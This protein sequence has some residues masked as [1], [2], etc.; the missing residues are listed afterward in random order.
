[1]HATVKEQAQGG[2]DIETETEIAFKRFVFRR[3]WFM[4][5][6]TDRKP[7]EMFSIPHGTD[8]ALCVR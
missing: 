8:H 3:S 5:S 4:L 7:F 2:S 1:M 6:L